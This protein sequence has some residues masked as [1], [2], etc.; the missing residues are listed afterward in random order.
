GPWLFRLGQHL[1]QD[2]IAQAM[3]TGMSAMEVDVGGAGAVKAVREFVVSRIGQE[4][5]GFGI[6]RAAA[7]ASEVGNAGQ[8]IGD[9]SIGEQIVVDLV[10][11]RN[12]DHISEAGAQGWSGADWRRTGTRNRG[13]TRR[14]CIPAAELPKH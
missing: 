11:E 5:V 14:C 2:V 6:A 8:A 1:D 12:L 3:R 13:G 4:L 7:V 9:E 10:Q